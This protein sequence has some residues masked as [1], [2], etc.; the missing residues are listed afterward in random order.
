M[1][2]NSWLLTAQPSVAPELVAG[3]EEAVMKSAILILLAG[4][5]EHGETGINKNIISTDLVH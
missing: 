1:Q 3:L 4:R 5:E 2:Q